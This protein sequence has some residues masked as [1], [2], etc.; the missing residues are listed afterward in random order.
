M[1]PKTT[2][3]L[4]IILIAAG[5]FYWLWSVQG[6]EQ[7]DQRAE[8]AQRI[9]PVEEDQVNKVAL[10]HQG[11]SALV[12]ERQNDE[13]RITFPVTTGANQ[14]Q[15][16]THLSAFLEAEKT[17]TLT[18]NPGANLAQYNL[19][20]PEYAAHI[21][22]SDTGKA[23]LLIGGENP[24]GSGV[25]AK[26]HK[27]SAVYLSN[28]N[29]RTQAEKEL[30][31]LRD[32]SI[33]MFDRNAVQKIVIE[34]VNARD[35][36]FEKADNTWR[37]TEPAIRVNQSEV[38]SILSSIQNG[39]AQEYFEEMAVNLEDYGL[40]NPQIT[41]SFF[42]DDTT[43]TAALI[44]GQPVD[45]SDSPQYYARDMTRPMVFSVNNNV[46]SNV[47]QDLFEFQDKDLFDV[48]QNQISD[49]II[50]WNDEIYEV[51]Q[52]DTAWQIVR[53][54]QQPADDDAISEIRRQIANLRMDESGS[55]TETEPAA[56][57]LDN[58]WL[59]VE[60]KVG[61]SDFDGFSIGGMGDEEMRYITTDSSPYVFQINTSKLE[62]FQVVL[63]DL[64]T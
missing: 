63:D 64:G 7:R 43:R 25:Y 10:F 18:E 46:Y 5:V 41:V 57:G 30:F 17:R 14:N 24:T 42:T 32:K 49:V 16:T 20:P 62:E 15:V 9:I 51:S 8:M 23:E 47:A 3:I 12:Y 11:D 21:F 48:S 19:A 56:Y 52:V 26:L 28:T 34:R 60:F 4:F 39:T 33:A 38:T 44:L 45:D 40:Q 61:G 29:I 22:Y 59:R 36:V 31:D 6:Q 2:L 58:P 37:I 1:K 35:L 53:P 27:A 54:V 13:W 55:Y 50:E